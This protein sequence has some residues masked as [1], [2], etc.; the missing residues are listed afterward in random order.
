[1]TKHATLIAH[2]EGE[3]AYLWNLQEFQGQYQCRAW[4]ITQAEADEIHRTRA[5]PAVIAR[6]ARHGEFTDEESV[7]R[8]FA[9][10]IDP[11][12]A[13]RA[14]DLLELLKAYKRP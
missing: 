7:F 2:D 8:F 14:D 9:G 1:M 10:D 5:A 3:N 12:L 11:F 4:D 6:P 13:T